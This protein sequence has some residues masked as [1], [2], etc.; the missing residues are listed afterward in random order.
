M[1]LRT[2]Q[3]RVV[4]R[5]LKTV[6]GVADVVTHGGLVKQYQVQPDLAKMKSFNIPLQQLLVALG[7]GN[8]N[9]GGSYV[10][11]G[12]QQYSIRGI[13]LLRTPT[14]SAML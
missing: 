9:T 14:T 11:K 1:D 8:S 12:E 6:P 3:D 5:Q 7:R 2:E 4:E 10:E 13:G